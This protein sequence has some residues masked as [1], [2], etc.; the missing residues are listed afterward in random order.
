[1]EKRDTGGL[2]SVH[3]DIIQAPSDWFWSE[4]QRGLGDAGSEE[5][6]W[7]TVGSLSMSFSRVFA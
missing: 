3:T 2:A 7:H 6:A 1:M 5:C 4:S